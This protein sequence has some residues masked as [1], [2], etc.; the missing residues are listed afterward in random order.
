MSGQYLAV[1]KVRSTNMEGPIKKQVAQSQAL[2][3]YIQ[4]LKCFSL[5]SVSNVKLKP[6]FGLKESV[7]SQVLLICILFCVNYNQDVHKHSMRKI[8]R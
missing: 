3:C 2:R 5:S 4:G 8:Q 6:A 7:T 1:K